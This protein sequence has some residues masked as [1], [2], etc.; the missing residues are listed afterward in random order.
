MSNLQLNANKM[1]ESDMSQYGQGGK[2]TPA[3]SSNKIYNMNG[4]GGVK[5]SEEDLLA[6]QI[7]PPTF[8]IEFDEPDLTSPILN[9]N[10]Q[11]IEKIVEFIAPNTGIN[12][13]L[14]PYNGQYK[15]RYEEEVK[16]Y[17]PPYSMVPENIG[18]RSD[19]QYDTLNKEADYLNNLV[20]QQNYTRFEQPPVQAVLPSKQSQ[21]FD[22]QTTPD[23]FIEDM[24]P[25]WNEVIIKLR[26][27]LYAIQNFVRFVQFSAI[28]KN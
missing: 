8:L 20:S 21:P 24:D 18:Y 7:E 15:P 13:Y 5:I 22:V 25:E 28:Y 11:E 26:F 6:C 3:S 12:G 23:K 19:M 2:S 1:Q 4:F 27:F 16:Y 17:Y 10:I 14:N 9:E